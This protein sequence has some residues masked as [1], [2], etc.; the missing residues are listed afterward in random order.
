LLAAILRQNPRFS[1]EMTSPMASLLAALHPKMC[2][3]EFVG[4][5]DNTKRAAILRGIFN[6]Y[7]GETSAAKVVFDTNRSWTGRIALLGE[8]YPQSR[9]IC[10]VREPG[11]IIDSIERMLAKN[12]LQLSRLFN[13]QPGSSVYSRAETLMNSET[14][15]IGLAWST[16]REAWFSDGASRLILV[17]YDRLVKNPKNTLERLYAALDEPPF[18]HDFSNVVY[19]APDYD[20]QLG[21]PGLHSVRKF[22]EYQARLPCIPPDIFAKY[23][24]TQFWEKPELNTRGVLII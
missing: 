20:L 16:L 18:T 17:T 19:D 10:C 5:F 1:A 6:T 4:F 9:I 2:S 21:M 3:G 23:V 12:P 7:Y 14:G 24:A 13:F 8:L 22:V 11:W 15:L